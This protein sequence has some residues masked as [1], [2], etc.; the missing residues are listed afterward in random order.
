MGYQSW[1]PSCRAAPWGGHA[2]SG[3][4]GGVG[5]AQS[6]G[7]RGVSQ[8]CWLGC[9]GCMCAHAGARSSDCLSETG[10]PCIW[11]APCQV[12]WIP[13]DTIGRPGALCRYPW[14]PWCFPFPWIP[15]VLPM[16]T[17]GAGT[18]GYPWCFAYPWYPWI[19]RVTLVIPMNA[20]GASH[21][22]PRVYS[23]VQGW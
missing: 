4:G 22:V 6:G 12:G 9:A 11:V 20:P 5:G 3:P 1:C 17:P 13:V 19:P 18:P 14:C 16:D 8:V 21:D 7:H 15:L 2:Q 10:G 23:S